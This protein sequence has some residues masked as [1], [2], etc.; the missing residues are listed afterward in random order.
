MSTS[1]H[2]CADKPVF[3]RTVQ[4]DVYNPG[5]ILRVHVIL[6]SGSQRSYISC[7]VKDELSLMSQNLQCLSLATFGRKNET[8]YLEMACVAM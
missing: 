5:V 1:T 7:G 4:V 2:V 6:D 8:K 3:L